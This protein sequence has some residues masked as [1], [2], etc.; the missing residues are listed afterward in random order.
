LPPVWPWR[1]PR[2]TFTPARLL[3]PPSTTTTISSITVRRRL[4]VLIAGRSTFAMTYDYQTI[5]GQAVGDPQVRST[6]SEVRS[7][8]YEV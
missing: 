8:K 1:A 2:R 4:T 6:K 5:N 3:V 7:L